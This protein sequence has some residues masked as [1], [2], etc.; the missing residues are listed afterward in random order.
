MESENIPYNQVPGYYKEFESTSAA[1]LVSPQVLE[2]ADKVYK[3]VPIIEKPEEIEILSRPVV[4]DLREK[5]DPLVCDIDVLDHKVASMVTDSPDEQYS[6][7]VGVSDKKCTREFFIE[8]PYPTRHLREDLV[9]SDTCY[10]LRRAGSIDIMKCIE[11]RKAILDWQRQGRLIVVK[12]EVHAFVQ[13]L[14]NTRYGSRDERGMCYE[15]EHDVVLARRIH[16]FGAHFRRVENGYQC[17]FDPNTM[18]HQTASNVASIIS[19]VQDMLGK[20]RID[21]IVLKAHRSHH[22]LY[23]KGQ[24]LPSLEVQ[25]GQSYLEHPLNT[26]HTKF[27]LNPDVG[28][29]N[30]QKGE[31]SLL[32]TEPRKRC[33]GCGVPRDQGSFSYAQWTNDTNRCRTCVSFLGVAYYYYQSIVE[34]L[35]SALR[36]K[37]LTGLWMKGSNCQLCK[38]SCGY[39]CKLNDGSQYFEQRISPYTFSF[40]A[41]NSPS[42]TFLYHNIPIVIWTGGRRLKDLPLRDHGKERAAILREIIFSPEHMSHSQSDKLGK[43]RDY[44][45]SEKVEKLVNCSKWYPEFS[46]FFV[47]EALSLSGYDEGILAD[48]MQKQS[49]LTLI[50]NRFVSEEKEKSFQEKEAF[51]QVDIVLS[52]DPYFEKTESLE[53]SLTNNKVSGPESG[54][55]SLEWDKSGENVQQQGFQVHWMYGNLRGPKTDLD[56][57]PGVNGDYH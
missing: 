50:S 17:S 9:L 40:C 25:D 30:A 24:V 57:F 38:N 10:Q 6:L 23:T 15:M 18:R 27:S 21:Q 33:T 47:L 28:E 4:I 1:K 41:E 8:T 51:S 19:A 20:E 48:L 37:S 34:T 32:Y 46:Y 49:F 14:M 5:Q 22:I 29:L 39:S 16:F 11:P 44:T 26:Y 3:V 56:F 7:F 45:L 36:Q 43:M 12:P 53:F 52:T 54:K 55:L 35:E 13:Q 42:S 2:Y 31:T